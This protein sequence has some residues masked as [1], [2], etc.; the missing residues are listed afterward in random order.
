MRKPDSIFNNQQKKNPHRSAYLDYQILNAAVP[1]VTS[2][3]QAAVVKTR[4]KTATREA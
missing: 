4:K 1:F 2:L 3:L